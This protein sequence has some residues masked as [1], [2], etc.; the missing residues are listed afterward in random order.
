[1]SSLKSN[2]KISEGFSNRL[3]RDT[4]EK[5]G[6]DGKKGKLTIGWG[7]NIDDKGLPTDILEMLLD[8]TINEAMD[9]L[10][11]NFPWTDNL[12]SIRREVLI[13]MLFNLGLD[14]FKGF[15][16]TLS[17][18]ENGNYKL[19]SEHMLDSLWARQVGIRAKKLA[20]KME[21]GQEK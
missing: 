12:D 11:N 21:T 19:A 3:Y 6:F 17:A 7:Y 8:R 10:S 5:I 16:G 2:I 15:K 14:T 9:E 13:E 1:M 20:R 18:V 4:S